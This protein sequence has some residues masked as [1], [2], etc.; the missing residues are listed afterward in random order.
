MDYLQGNY[1][2]AGIMPTLEARAGVITLS[3][4]WD[5]LLEQM[6]CFTNMQ[7]SHGF[8]GALKDPKSRFV[9]NCSGRS[10]GFPQ[11][12]QIFINIRHKH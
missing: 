8:A 6:Y 3:G 1:L 7:T 5:K 4:F 2:W 12:I 10:T 11:G 9:A